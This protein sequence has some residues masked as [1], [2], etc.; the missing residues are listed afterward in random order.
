[1]EYSCDSGLHEPTRLVD[2]I[3]R[4]SSSVLK[5]LTWLTSA[6]KSMYSLY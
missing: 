3:L 5:P 1:M 2:G 6:M 4:Q